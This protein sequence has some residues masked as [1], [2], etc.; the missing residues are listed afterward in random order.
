SKSRACLSAAQAAKGSKTACRQ[1][2]TTRRANAKKGKSVAST[3]SSRTAVRIKKRASSGGGGGKGGIKK[4]KRPRAGSR[5]GKTVRKHGASGGSASSKKLQNLSKE[6]A[7][8]VVNP[9][10]GEVD[11][12]KLDAPDGTL[13]TNCNLDEGCES[14]TT[15]STTNNGTCNPD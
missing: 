2:G 8:K 5:K 12:S 4:R 15:D 6:Q 10:T 13:N 3:R 11:L 9:E 7:T 1:V 14:P